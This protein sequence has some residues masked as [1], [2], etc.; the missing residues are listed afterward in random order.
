[1]AAPL[2]F[3]TI[4]VTVAG[5]TVETLADDNVTVSVD[6]ALQ[7]AVHGPLVLLVGPPPLQPVKAA[8]AVIA[9]AA[10]SHFFILMTPIKFIFMLV[11]NVRP[12]DP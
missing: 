5:V 8:N 9:R 3:L 7:L 11:F 2:P 10:I 6:A 1:M 4:A 12:C